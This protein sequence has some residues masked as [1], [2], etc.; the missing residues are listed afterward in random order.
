MSSHPRESQ[1][2]SFAMGELDA[3]ATD[4]VAEHLSECERCERV[5]AAEQRL[6]ELV[7][8][9]APVLG[10]DSAERALAAL[11]ARVD[12]E[13]G[14][15]GEA[16]DDQA[17]GPP[18]AAPAPPAEA[19]A[20]SSNLQLPRPSPT[21]SAT[22]RWRR[23]AAAAALL[24][25]TGALAWWGTRANA[26][27]GVA[28]DDG[29]TDKLVEVDTPASDP[30]D[31]EAPGHAPSPADALT[32][33]AEQLAAVDTPPPGGF[34]APAVDVAELQRVRERVA[35]ALA[36]VDDYAL[37]PQAFATEAGEGLAELRQEGW[38]VD[39]HLRRIALGD[40]ANAAARALCYVATTGSAPGL[41]AEALGRGR[42][43][44]AVL[45]WMAPED[46][47]LDSSP[48]L[49]RELGRRAARGEERALELLLA[50]SGTRRHRQL[51]P[52]LEDALRDPST[53]PASFEAL[54]RACPPAVSLPVLAASPESPR[55]AALFLELA[56]TAPEA[57][58]D[59]LRPLLRGA[60]PS[61]PRFDWIVAAGLDALVPALVAGLEDRDAQLLSQRRLLLL[62]SDA[63]L[64]A[65][66]V[67]LAEDLRGE[68]DMGALAAH[69]DLRPER[70]LALGRSVA[71][72]HAEALLAFAESLTPPASEALL[73]GALDAHEPGRDDHGR[74]AEWLV[75]LGRLG[76][77]DAGTELLA[78][79]AQLPAGDPVLPL[80]WATAGRL[81]GS[82]AQER[83]LGRGGDPR[84][85]S[86]VV[87]ATADRFAAQRAPSSSLLRPLAQALH[88]NSPRLR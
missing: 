14:E 21:T 43:E 25:T 79:L 27:G 42:H 8:K 31:T 12:A 24:I 56:P 80:M 67:H 75:A 33:T 22:P 5:V 53:E 41:L 45:S 55:A 17:F 86:R 71:R 34:S 9:A 51:T 84:L 15:A 23:L 63:A 11:W 77:Q 26:P 6:D 18:S 64:G 49:L 62:G 28:H 66:F 10:G 3:S 81:A 60:A 61:D 48:A 70:A 68:L 1:L 47:S 88:R 37:R 39:A 13:A 54:A 82:R 76:T 20:P 30:T 35:A 52:L 65:L 44:Q 50:E 83:W 36:V 46:A 40:D 4:A 32:S 69:I 59:A 7:L 72:S 87:D 78:R 85:L 19:D 57:A 16:G 73:F 2:L 58:T 29:S 38:P 74:R